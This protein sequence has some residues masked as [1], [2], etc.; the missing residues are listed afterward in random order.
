MRG[1]EVVPHPVTCSGEDDE[2]RWDRLFGDPR[3]R[4]V[5][6]R[7]A[8]EALEEEKAG[9]THSQ[10]DPSS[11]QTNPPPTAALRRRLLIS[12]NILQPDRS[13][14]CVR[15]AYSLSYNRLR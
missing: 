14:P 7:M 15:V 10:E 9:L 3:S 2:E 13:N 1:G 5:L 4:V 12:V 6:E 11:C 8:A